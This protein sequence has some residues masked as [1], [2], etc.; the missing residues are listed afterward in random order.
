MA[1]GSIVNPTKPGETAPEVHGN[2]R[3]RLQALF[4]ST[5]ALPNGTGQV[6]H[7]QGVAALSPGTKLLKIKII[8][9]NMQTSLPK[10]RQ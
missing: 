1:V 5:Q 10:V 3:G 7:A 9:W 4:P 6:D 8:T 2:V